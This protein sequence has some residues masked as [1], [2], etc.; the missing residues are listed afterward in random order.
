[1]TMVKGNRF[2]EVLT[3]GTHQEPGIMVEC[4]NQ[5]SQII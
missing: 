3:Q 1:M 2:T 4:S 5:G